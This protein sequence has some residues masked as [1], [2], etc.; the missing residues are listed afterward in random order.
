MKAI[1]QPKIMGSKRVE[2]GEV[3]PVEV[4]F[5]V[6]IDI[7]SACNFKCNFCFHSDLEAIKRAD[8]RFGSM[9]Y[10][11]FC[12]IIDDMKEQ[13]GFNKVK[14]LR[15]FKVGEPL[16]NKDVCN[17]IAYAK[18]A[19]VAEKIEITTNGV[20][21]NPDLNQKMIDAGLDILNIS[22][23]GIDEEQYRKVCKYELTMEK[24]LANIKDF[25]DRKGDKCRLTV[26][27]GDIGYTQREKD[28]FYELF[29]DKCD[30]MFVETISDTLWQDTNIA[31][32]VKKADV[33]TYGEELKY[34]KVCPFLFTTMVINE[35]GMVHL[36]CADWKSE[37]VIGDLNKESINDIWKGEKLK[38]I[39]IMHL[40]GQKDKMSICQKCQS[41]SANTP[42]NMDPYVDAVLHR[43]GV[44]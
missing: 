23:N 27:Y 33:G 37:Y 43:M 31:D 18:K 16:L 26:K 10:K 2:L 19:Q 35:S 36:C 15:L 42:D 44:E 29:G 30:E 1:I 25:Y 7:C 38:N 13:W 9:S 4:P 14:K 11:L 17:M 39:Q 8:V 6:Q 32:N 24:F 22:V 21:L 5:S 12:K 40:K 3:A 34:K 41:L 28:R 20:L